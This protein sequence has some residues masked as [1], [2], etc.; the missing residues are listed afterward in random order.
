MR[1]DVGEGPVSHDDGGQ[2]GDGEDRRDIV[3]RG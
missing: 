3:G 1:G 2:R